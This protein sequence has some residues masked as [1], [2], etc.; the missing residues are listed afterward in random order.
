MPFKSKTFVDEPVT[1]SRR[2]RRWEE[3]PESEAAWP[4]KKTEK[5]E[6]DEI[7]QAVEADE[8]SALDE[9]SSSLQKARSS[10][11]QKRWPT[12]RRAHALGFA[13]LLLF[14][15][16]T[17]FRP[18]ENISAL[19]GFTSMAFWLAVATL[20]VFIPT[21]LSI[22]GTLTARPREINLVLLL[23]LTALVSIPF[24]IDPSDAWPAFVDFAKVIAMFIVMI[25]VVR[26][27]RRWRLMFWLA[28]LVSVALSVYALNDYL[29]GHFD[30]HGNRIEGLIQRG[31]FDNPN[32]MA[33]HLVT[34]IP[35]AIGL[36]FVARGLPK[37]LIYG[38]CV[39]L[40]IV[41]V[42]VTFSRG[43]FL[44]LACAMFVMAWKLGRRNRVGVVMLFLVV[45]VIFF[46]LV[47]HDYVGRLLTVFGGSDWQGGSAGARQN[48]LLR[49]LVVMVRHPIFGIGMNNF[50]GVSIHDQVSHNAYTQVGA[51]I[52]LIALALY[53]LFIWTSFRR[54]RQIERET[55]RSRSSAR[56]YY[57]AVGL[58]AGLIG[59]MVSSFFASVAYLWYIYYLVGYALCLHR[60]YEAK[61][62]EGVFSRTTPKSRSVNA[63]EEPSEKP[64]VPFAE[65]LAAHRQQ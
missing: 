61:G 18:Y 12:L 21:Q 40:M 15:A 56:V 52:G 31:L 43:G 4:Q 62:A 63:T 2:A 48:L 55:Y 6:K 47:P 64:T 65:P 60:L 50:R 14:T 30:P 33:L 39:L 10:V 37:K 53:V 46:A 19:S 8:A 44:A 22:E 57:L 7:G 25:N 13:G 54:M 20:L 17:Y 23:L 34:M 41:G 29:L 26:T 16:T 9:S 58:Q 28:L 32:D 51:E 35:L 27:E 42:V 3:T 5:P 24:A 11:S 49:S 45:G 38:L 1:R 59:Y 36:L